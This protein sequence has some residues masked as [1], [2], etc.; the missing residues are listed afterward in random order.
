V[1]KEGWTNERRAIDID[2]FSNQPNTANPS[3]ISRGGFSR[4]TSQEIWQLNQKLLD[5]QRPAEMKNAKKM[6]QAKMAFRAVFIKGQ[7]DDQ[8]RVAEMKLP[9]KVSKKKGKV[10][11]NGK[12]K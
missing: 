10:N 3:P 6:A 12:K 4:M 8:K 1:K 7:Q 5:E 11:G 2:T 9:P